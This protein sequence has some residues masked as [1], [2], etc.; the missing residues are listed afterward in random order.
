MLKK[1]SDRFW[2]QSEILIIKKIRYLVIILP[3]TVEYNGSLGLQGVIPLSR[4]SNW[5]FIAVFTQ[6][7]KGG[8]G[9]QKEKVV[10][11]RQG[12]IK[13]RKKEKKKKGRGGGR[14]KP[15]IKDTIHVAAMIPRCYAK[16]LSILIAA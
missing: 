3:V 2:M 7:K 4:A 5:S 11:G 1:N 6:K 9:E 14:N 10:S 16:N 15:K 13:E 12:R 8:G